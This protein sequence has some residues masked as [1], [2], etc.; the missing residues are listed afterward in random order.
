M[1]HLC[2]ITSLASSLENSTMNPA[3][4]LPAE[5]LPRT[6]SSDGVNIVV[7]KSVDA[8]SRASGCVVFNI[9]DHAA[10]EVA[11][12]QRHVTI[13][14]L[15]ARWEKDPARRKAMEEARGWIA[16]SFHE[17]D[18]DTVRTMR[19]RRGWSQARLAQALGTSQSHVARIERGTENLALATCR[20]LCV[21]LAIDMNMLDQAL[22]RQEQLAHARAVS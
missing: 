1:P 22:R 10:R 13:E 6:Q 21:V 14:A 19:L 3:I 18:G 2:G 15:N 5:S 20:R 17:E 12:P 8:T 9:S 11:T 16:D 7:G 4:R